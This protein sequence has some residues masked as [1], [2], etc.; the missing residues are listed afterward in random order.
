M[1]YR[2]RFCSGGALHCVVEGQVTN[3]SR[4]IDY[5]N[6]ALVSVNEC[7][8]CTLTFSVRA[9]NSDFVPIVRSFSETSL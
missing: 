1:Q 8:K 2:A 7:L 5:C 4:S 6:N 3:S 9:F